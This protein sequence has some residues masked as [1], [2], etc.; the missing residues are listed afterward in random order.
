MTSA[1]PTAKKKNPLFRALRGLAEDF[2]YDGPTP[3]FWVNFTGRL[4]KTF[5]FKP[6]RAAAK[7][8]RLDVSKEEIE[9]RRHKT[10]VAATQWKGTRADILEAMW[11][12]GFHLPGGNTYIDMLTTPLG[13]KKEMSVLDVSAGLGSVG[14]R[15]ALTRG[16]FTIGLEPDATIVPRAKERA[17]E[18]DM[19]VKAPVTAYDPLT[20]SSEKH[21]HC[22]LSR[23]FFFKIKNK[24][25]FF[26]EIA[27]T[28]FPDNSPRGQVTF[29][30]FI[31]EDSEAEK[32]A[33]K[34]WL[35]GEREVFPVSLEK[36]RKT[37]A[38][39]GLDLRVSEEITDKYRRDV[40]RGFASLATFLKD[41]EPDEETKRLVLTEMRVWS[42]RAAAMK[43]GLKIF[44]FY[45]I[46]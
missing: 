13:L 22:I 21:Y 36:M 24:P 27:S 11:G 45:A 42:L 19:D 10:A 32:P 29:T 6:N 16:V 17:I 2:W 34:A 20:F 15:M 46:R 44:R 37:M 31:L 3:D 40:L 26:K 23:E 33:V 41:H 28:L 38:G 1:T 14:R 9:A 7:L 30:D 18:V 5:S 4:K 35:S 12:K 25:I 43:Q 39:A 8:E